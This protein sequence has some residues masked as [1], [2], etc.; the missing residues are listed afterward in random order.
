M[1]ADW[2]DI[3]QPELRFWTW[4]I[5]PD[6]ILSRRLDL[7]CWILVTEQ[8]LSLQIEKLWRH[9]WKTPKIRIDVLGDF[10]PA[11]KALEWIAR[12][13][14][15]TGAPAIARLAWLGNLGAVPA[16]A[17]IVTRAYDGRPVFKERDWPVPAALWAG[18]EPTDPR[19]TINSGSFYAISGRSEYLLEGVMWETDPLLA[20][21]HNLA[22]LGVAGQAERSPEF[23]KASPRRGRRKGT[24]GYA[25]QDA[26]I[27]AKIRAMIESS[28]ANSPWDAA[29]AL[30][31]EI[32]GAGTDDS[33]RKRVVE[34]YYAAHS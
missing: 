14:A 27:V 1:P 16:V 9:R 13:T 18:V 15:E 7:P 11:T 2:W 26:R 31:D 32:P 24:G 4:S 10:A 34:A 12:I 29:G 22:A 6:D 20:A 23:S 17:G 21:L 5:D 30:L 28:E 25:K 3:E 19:N 8:S 33:R